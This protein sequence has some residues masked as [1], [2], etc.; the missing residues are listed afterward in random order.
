MRSR[1]YISSIFNVSSAKNRTRPPPCASPERGGAARSG[2]GVDPHRMAVMLLIKPKNL[3]LQIELPL[4]V[5]FMFLG[6][7]SWQTV[8]LLDGCKRELSA[9]SNSGGLSSAELN[10]DEAEEARLMGLPALSWYQSQ[11]YPT[12]EAIPAGF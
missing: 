10:L 4:I 7:P 8:G 3:N 11:S 12:P 2:R 9:L 1:F 6:T 5:R